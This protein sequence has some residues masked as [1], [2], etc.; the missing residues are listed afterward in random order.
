MD[1]LDNR[2]GIPNNVLYTCVESEKCLIG[3]VAHLYSV[4]TNEGS[5]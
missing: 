2:M 4:A 5:E 1:D 3:K